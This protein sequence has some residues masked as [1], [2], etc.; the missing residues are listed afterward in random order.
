M[1]KISGLEFPSAS[2]ICPLFSTKL[3]YLYFNMLLFLGSA[4]RAYWRFQWANDRSWL[5][6]AL[7]VAY[8]ERR[9]NVLQVLKKISRS[10]GAIKCLRSRLSFPRS[11]NSP[12]IHSIS[13]DEESEIFRDTQIFCYPTT[14]SLAPILQE[15]KR[16]SAKTQKNFGPLSYPQMVSS[17]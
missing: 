16:E 9:W 11:F 3:V 12:Q 5:V 10:C 6:S 17:I 7:S 1:Y 15:H 14:F 8:F 13:T 4:F 2:L